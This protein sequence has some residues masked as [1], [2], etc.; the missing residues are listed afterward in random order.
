MKLGKK[1]AVSGKDHIGL[2]VGAV[3]L[4]NKTQILLIKRS[5]KLAKER[6]TV[7][8]WSIPGGEVEFAETAEDAICREVREELGIVIRIKKLIGHWDQILPKA[9]VHWHSVTF[10]CSIKSGTPSIK[11]PEK[12][13]QL[14]WFDLKKLPKN[15]GVAHVAAPLVMLGKMSRSEFKKRRKEPPES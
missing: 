9:K 1:T 14:K 11:E 8:M 12:T 7:G 10:L 15:S 5:K 2:G 13:V 6:T 3:I 4:R